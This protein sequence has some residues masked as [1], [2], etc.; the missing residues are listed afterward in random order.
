MNKKKKTTKS[1]TTDPKV[2]FRRSKQWAT[3]R[4]KVKKSQKKDPVTDSPLTKNFNLHHLDERPQNYTDISDESHF[5]GLNSTT[6]TVLHFLW[7]D[8]KRR[9]DWKK[10]IERLA[11]LCVCMDDINKEN[12]DKND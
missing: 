4:Q 9:Y 6:H 8:G 12:E 7:G 10:R 3:F 5:I 11:E 2:V 1:K